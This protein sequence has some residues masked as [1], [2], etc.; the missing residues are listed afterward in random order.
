[1]NWRPNISSGLHSV[2]ILTE[3][4]NDVQTKYSTDEYSAL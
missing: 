3:E 2:Y 4:G 1:M